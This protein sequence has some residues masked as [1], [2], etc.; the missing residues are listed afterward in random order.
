MLINYFKTAL[1]TLWRYKSYTFI[2]IIGLA[3]AIAAM[4]WGY[5]DYRFA[6]SYDS[7]HKDIDHV[8]RGLTYRQG[9]DGVNGIFPMPAVRSA[10]NDFAGITD[11]VRLHRSLVNVKAGKDETFSESV[12]FTDPS[13]FNLFNFPL[14]TGSNNLNDP[15][16]VLVTE[17][18]A[19]KYFGKDNPVGKTLLFY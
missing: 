16:A 7:F 6:F 17:N 18:T 5:Q 8:Y 13:F 9:A 10:K 3:I 14:L 19:K 4:V 2:N 15:N 12:S 11:V 1:R